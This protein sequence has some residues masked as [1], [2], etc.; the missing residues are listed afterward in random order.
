MAL[1]NLAELMRAKMTLKN[2]N[3]FWQTTFS[4]SISGYKSR[5]VNMEVRDKATRKTR[6]MH[7]KKGEAKVERHYKLHLSLGRCWRKK[8]EFKN[9]PPIYDRGRCKRG[10]RYSSKS[11]HPS[12]STSTKRTSAN[13]PE[14]RHRRSRLAVSRRRASY[15]KRCFT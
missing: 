11:N 1:L 12:D 2:N 9:L 8:I 5:F 14:P 6:E 7:T 13:L 10:R 15:D 3:W 4:W